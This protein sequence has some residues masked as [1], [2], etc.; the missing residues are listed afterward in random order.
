MPEPVIQVRP[1]G[2]Y[3]PAA[4]LH[5]DPRR[6]VRR[7]II[8][9]AH[10]D[11][12]RAGHGRI[13]ASPTSR[14]LLEHRLPGTPVSVLPWRTRHPFGKATISLHPAGHVLGS[15][16]VRV[17]VDRET[18]VVSGDYKR[19]ADPTCETFESVP[20]DTFITEATFALPVYRWPE[21][22]DVATDVLRWIRH[23]RDQ[24][25][26]SLLL[27]YSLGKAQRVLAELHRHPEAQ[28]VLGD[29]VVV[30]DAV[31]AINQLY[32]DAGIDLPPTR[33]IEDR[34]T[35]ERRAPI[36]AIAPPAVDGSRWAKRLGV[37]DH[38]FVSG[39]MRIRG[40]RRRRAASRGFLL[41]DHADWPGLLRTIEESGARRVLVTHGR[42]D[43]LVRV[44][45]ERGVAAA[46][47]EGPWEPAGEE[48]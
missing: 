17:E 16:Q 47:L 34:P 35:G 30:H 41:S 42:P 12:A 21:P 7:A 23:N 40:I 20:C 13:L 18:W 31:A 5:I 33:R 2:L 45:R 3:V 19:Q 48:G 11:H 14:A 26:S 22:A 36:V 15:A 8:T 44:L 4:D 6:A 46:P 38:A 10:A 39:W 27:A 9:H 32:R 24:G 43:V 37:H 28:A 25:R 29:P 1:E